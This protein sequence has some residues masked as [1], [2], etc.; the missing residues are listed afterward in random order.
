MASWE[1]CTSISL[2]GLIH[3]G[4]AEKDSVLDVNHK[5]VVTCVVDAETVAFLSIRLCIDWP[6]FKNTK[7]L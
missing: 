5:T 2:G 1:I 3:F 6:I 7:C 4:R